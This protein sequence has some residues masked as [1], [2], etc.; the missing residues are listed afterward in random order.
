MKKLVFVLLVSI[1]ASGCATRTY[2]TSNGALVTRRVVLPQVAISVKV[3]NDCAP[4]LDLETIAGIVFPGLKYSESATV[5]LMPVSSN[6]G[7]RSMT[8]TVKGYDPAKS[9]YLGSDERQFSVS[10]YSGS[11]E[12][13]WRVTSISLPNGRGGCQ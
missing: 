3:T 10:T 5:P 8:L 9:L 7:T 12:D 1:A 11:N 13:T 2:R 6:Q 4:I